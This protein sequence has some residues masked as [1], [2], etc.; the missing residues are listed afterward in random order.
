MHQLLQEHGLDF[1]HFLDQLLVERPKESNKGHTQFSYAEHKS[2][3]Q[4]KISIVTS[5][6]ETNPSP[7]TSPSQFSPTEVGSPPI[8][9]MPSPSPS[10]SSAT[11]ISTRRRTPAPPSAFRE[12]SSPRSITPPPP[13]SAP[14]HPPS[15]HRNR[16]RTPVPLPSP[17]PMSPASDLAPPAS[18]PITGLGI[19]VRN[20]RTPPP[21]S[22]AGL[23]AALTPGS[24]RSG[25]G[26]LGPTRAR[27]VDEEKDREPYS[28]GGRVKSV[29]TNP[30]L[31]PR[32]VKR[33]GSSSGL[34]PRSVVPQR[35]GM[36]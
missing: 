14:S 21:S 17:M 13:P 10:T 22:S 24:G 30:S 29:R 34:T 7:F 5:P 20:A 16:S 27:L 3:R 15:P 8:Q 35:E 23:P 36:F 19:S 11:P 31:P 12:P 2:S 33:P 32:S 28:P 1:R 6:Q 25:I 18:A 9:R 4:P 26:Q